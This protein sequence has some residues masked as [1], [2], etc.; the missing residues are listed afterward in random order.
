MSSKS[1]EEFASEVKKIVG[2]ENV[3]EKPEELYPY[4]YD[5]TFI[6]GKVPKLAVF[7]STPEEISKIMKL[8]NEYR[9]P[10]IPRGRGS[11]LSGGPVTIVDNSVVLN[12]LKLNKIIEISPENKYM[13]VEAGVT[14]DEIEAALASY[15]YMFPPDPASSVAATIGGAIAANAGGIRGAKHGT[16]K[17]WV[18]GLEVV[19]P[20]GE[21]IELGNKTL[22][23]RQGPDLVGL[24]T[25]SEG[26]LAIITKAALKIYPRPEKVVR[27]LA[28][29]DSPRA[30]ANLVAKFA[31]ER[32]VPLGMEFLDRLTM[33]ALEKAKGMKFPEA[34]QFLML[35]DIDGPP[36]A[37]KRY[38]DKAV[39]IVKSENPIDVMYSD[40]PVEMEKLYAAR[41]GAYASL[42]KIR[43]KPTETVYMED[44]VVPAT[45]L[46][47]MLEQLYK[48][49]EKYDIQTPTFGHIGDGNLHPNLIFDLADPDSVKRAEELFKETCKV[50]VEL[51]G[52][53]SGEHGIGVTRREIF[54]EALAARKSEKIYDLIVGI[55]KVFDPNCILNPGKIID[56]C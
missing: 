1:F 36:E 8:A 9:V 50:A 4:K 18:L 46:P 13:I 51:G 10:I 39:D 54:K 2:A 38:M 23:W 41:K 56:T 20:T 24:I 29:F 21:I 28:Y 15:G 22:K 40:D 42:L 45:K 17:H 3:Q 19:L 32:I 52:Y 53:I 6:I 11:S 14:V 30:A 35:I 26:I 31:K 16:T 43:K 55:K 25:G 12:L 48:L 49:S 5:A 33:D 44:V 7:P 37:M 34:A 27:I 47:D